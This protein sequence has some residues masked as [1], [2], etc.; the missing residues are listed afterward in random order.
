MRS[1]PNLINQ[2]PSLQ[3]TQT[4][5]LLVGIESEAGSGLTMAALPQLL[6]VSLFLSWPNVQVGSLQCCSFSDSLLVFLLLL[7]PLLKQLQPFAFQISDGFLH[8]D[9]GRFVQAQ[10]L[11]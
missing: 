9:A 11:A 1:T 5:L 2:Q 8:S 3:P 10:L 6:I 7:G 4:D